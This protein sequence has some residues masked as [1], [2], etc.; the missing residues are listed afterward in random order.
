MQAALFFLESSTVHGEEYVKTYQTI[1]EA[2][3]R[4]TAARAVG[5]AIGKNP[6][7]YL[8]PCHRVI[9]GSGELGGYRWGIERKNVLLAWEASRSVDEERE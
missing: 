2:I 9:K 7:G 6:I 3:D 4:P 8:I 5:N 1:A